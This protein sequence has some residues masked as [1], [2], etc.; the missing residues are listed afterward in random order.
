MAKNNK[1]IKQEGTI[2]Q[3]LGYENFRVELDNGMEILATPSGRIRQC[4][5]KVM[6]GDR[7]EVELSPYDLKR[8]RITYRYNLTY[9]HV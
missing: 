1:H 5:V 3:A 4:H 6:T 8:G 9:S 2:T 7:V